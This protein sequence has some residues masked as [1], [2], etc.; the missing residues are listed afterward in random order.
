MSDTARS[1]TRSDESDLAYLKRLAVA[2]R[3]EPA[4]FLLLMAVFGGVYGFAALAVMAALLI[5]GWPT[6]GAAPGP[7][8]RFL[9]GWIFVAAHLAFLAALLWTGWRTFGPNRVSLNRAA[10][11]TWTAAFIGLVVVVAM[12]RLFTRNE[13]STDAVYAA[14]LLGPMV[15]VLWGCAWWVT[16]IISERRWLL[17]VAVGSFAAALALAWVGNSVAMLPIMGL[18]LVLLAFAPAVTLMRERRA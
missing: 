15:L 17:G 3:G 12:I 4:P 7:A 16:A 5:D 1:A 13:P 10:S 9:G 14:H 8:T 18:S 6:E 11:A 2:G